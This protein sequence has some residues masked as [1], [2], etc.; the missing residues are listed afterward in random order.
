VV[1]RGRFTARPADAAAAGQEWC[2][3][4]LLARIHRYTLNRLRAEI[5]PVSAADFMRFLLGWQRVDPEHRVAGLEGLATVIAQLEA[6]E[7]PAAAWESDV[8]TSRCEDTSRCC[9]IRCA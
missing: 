4:R 5:E 6:F 3:R 9:W 1:L 8:L 7:L 2:E